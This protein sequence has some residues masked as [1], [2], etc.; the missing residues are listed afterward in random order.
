MLTFGCPFSS[1]WKRCP[2]GAPKGGGAHAIRSRP[3]MFRE[4]RP[5]SLWLHFGLHFG[6]VWAPKSELY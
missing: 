2:N 3:R 6:V 1:L 5:S 4:G